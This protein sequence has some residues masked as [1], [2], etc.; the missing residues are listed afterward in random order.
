M[1]SNNQPKPQPK[2]P[3]GRALHLTDAELDALSEVTPADVAD[4][5]ALIDKHGSE[6]LKGLARA[7]KRKRD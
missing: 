1:D 4:A 7:K 6:R 5:L 3:K 2:R